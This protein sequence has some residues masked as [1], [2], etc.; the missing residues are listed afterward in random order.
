RFAQPVKGLAVCLAWVIFVASAPAVLADTTWHVDHTAT[1]TETG[2]TWEDAF[3]DLQDALAVA[4]VDDEIWVAKGVYRPDRGTLDRTLTFDL[5]VG[6]AIYGGFVG[7]ENDRAQANPDLNPTVLSGDLL[8]NDAGSFMNRADN[9]LHVVR[10][11]H[12]AIDD[13]TLID[14]LTISGGHADGDTTET[15][16][17]GGI[18][19]QTAGLDLRRCTLVD[20]YAMAGGGAIAVDAGSLVISES[21]VAGNA[22]DEG[23]AGVRANN[24]S[25]LQIEAATF[26][27][28]TAGRDEAGDAGAAIQ[29]I[30]GSLLIRDST[31][32][33]QAAD[34][35]G[36]AICVR[37]ATTTVE[38]CSFDGNMSYESGGAIASVDGTLTFLNNTTTANMSRGWSTV[39]GGA[40]HVCGADEA[41]IADSTFV[42]DFASYPGCGGAICIEDASGPVTVLHSTFDTAEAGDG[43]GLAATQSDLLTIRGCTFLNC[44]AEFIGGALRFRASIGEVRDTT[45]IACVSA[46]AGGGIGLVSSD[47]TIQTSALIGNN[48]E[49]LDGGGLYIDNGQ[50]VLISTVLNGNLSGWDGGGIFTT[51]ASAVSLLNC[52]IVENSARELGGGVRTTSGTVNAANSI[53]WHNHASGSGERAQFSGGSNATLSA[54]FCIIEDYE[55]LIPGEQNFDADPMFVFPEGPDGIIGTDDDDLRLASDSPAVD[56]GANDLIA[57]MNMHDL[58]GGP[59]RVDDAAVTDTGRGDAPIVDLGA[60]ERLSGDAAII[61]ESLI[62]GQAGKVNAISVVNIIPQNTVYFASATSGGESLVPQC[63]SLRLELGNPRMIGTATADAGGTA[64]L[65]AFVPPGFAEQILH[66]Q[67]VD[68]RACRHSP[69]LLIVPGTP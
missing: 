40:I 9:A 33:D 62:P 20:N 7:S 43:G 65:E 1:G 29:Q 5:T 44:R 16:I 27:S 41:I 30:G 3:T 55:D 64:T 28:N 19:L 23:G 38:R 2:E 56:R 17:G 35:R 54:D 48:A 24:E 47:F 4:T 13:V 11:N 46:N 32:D 42:A 61:W 26:A 49:F 45:A 10:V 52:T 22:S 50:A 15:S 36:G 63:P 18:H 68:P 12:V 8:G 60:Y 67:A 31:F 14:G 25:R 66:L 57:Q 21:E 34:G 39:G 6:I 69:P 37:N 58:A 59:R 53:F 51:N